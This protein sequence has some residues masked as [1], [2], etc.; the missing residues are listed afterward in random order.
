[1]D[2]RGYSQPPGDK[3]LQNQAQ[4]LHR[5]RT[6]NSELGGYKEGPH[7]NHRRASPIHPAGENSLKNENALKDL[8]A[9][10]KKDL[11]DELAIF[12]T[13]RRNLEDEREK[14]H[15]QTEK[16]QRSKDKWRIPNYNVLD[17][18]VPSSGEYKLLDEPSTMHPNELEAYAIRTEAKIPK[19]QADIDRRRHEVHMMRTNPQHLEG[20]SYEPHQS[21]TYHMVREIL[22]EVADGILLF[23][24]G[25]WKEDRLK[26][27]RVLEQQERTVNEHKLHLLK[28]RISHL[29]VEEIILEVSAKLCREIVEEHQS[30]E[31]YIRAMT[32]L[33]VINSAEAVATKKKEGRDEADPA[34]SL[35]TGTYHQMMNERQKKREKIWLHTQKLHFVGEEEDNSDISNSGYDN[36]EDIQVLHFQDTDVLNERRSDLIPAALKIYFI[37]E[38]DYWKNMSVKMSELKVIR[39]TK[40]VELTS[41]SPDHRLLAI[42]YSHGDILVYD[43]W[44]SPVQLTRLISNESIYNDPIISFKWSWDGMR[45]ISVNESGSLHM[46]SMVSGGFTKKDTKDFEVV[47]G[48][49]NTHPQQLTLY[50]AL[51]P[52]DYKFK[53]GPL[54]ESGTET[55]TL[56]PSLSCFYPSQTLL[57]TQNEFVV[58]FDNG[59]LLK[60]NIEPLI[61]GSGSDELTPEVK[62]FPKVNLPNQPNYIGQDI[63]A[64]L[65]R[66]HEHPLVLVGC[67]GNR[68]NV[69]SVDANGYINVWEYNKK[70]VSHF[71]WFEPLARYRL[72]M[73]ERT[74]V[75][76]D[77]QTQQVLFDEEKYKSKKKSTQKI[78]TNRCDKEFNLFAVIATRSFDLTPG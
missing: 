75:R 24:P 74:F 41:L 61:A 16:M 43:L 36:D 17:P 10:R 34:Y 69:L 19:L 39:R 35:V 68:G 42:G 27:E 6:T 15:E 58:G 2:P 12:R 78:L 63:P 56:G 4:L 21:Q 73:V 11:K 50:A 62:T 9:K 51:A 1:M 38:R 5:L 32:Q 76:V 53:Q 49:G 28:E 59:D 55:A 77:G 25:K 37:K 33:L 45:L 54:A 57:G 3:L 46:W 18:I 65:F 72:V 23:E 40:G 71:G 67:I 7:L 29:L 52:K 13:D 31:N 30:T 26:V 64:D 14:L 44:A 8:L 60:C 66:C 20:W 70:H 47:A 22:V 48:R